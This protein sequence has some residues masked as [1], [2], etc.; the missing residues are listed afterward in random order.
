MV[1]AAE[2]CELTV[3]GW[4]ALRAALAGHT[5]GALPDER[6]RAV[7]E[8]ALLPS[9]GEVPAMQPCHVAAAALRRLRH[10]SLGGAAAA[11]VAGWLPSTAARGALSDVAATT[12]GGEAPIPPA[13]PVPCPR[14]GRG[15]APYCPETGA[16]HEWHGQAEW[17]SDEQ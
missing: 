3:E 15:F 4:A 8:V 17:Q 6:A 16:P 1:S 12:G 13:A 2:R 11:A 7:A 5:A 9:A 10:T 14:C